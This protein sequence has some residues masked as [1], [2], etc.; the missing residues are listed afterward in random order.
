[1]VLMSSITLMSTFPHSQVPPTHWPAPHTS[2]HAAPSCSAVYW[3][4]P[5][6]QV[7]GAQGVPPVH[8]GAPTQRP[9]W[10]VALVWQGSVH[11]I[12]SLNDTVRQPSTSSQTAVAHCKLSPAVLHATGVPSHADPAVALVWHMPAA[13]HRV[14]GHG[15]GDALVGVP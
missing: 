12:P 3:Q 15:I 11:F 2:V 6:L 8:T 5:L 1:M 10:Q 9:L 7:A 14:D 13:W 4:P